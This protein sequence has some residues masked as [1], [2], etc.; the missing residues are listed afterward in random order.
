MTRVSVSIYL[1]LQLFFGSLRVL[2]VE[3]QQQCMN[4]QWVRIVSFQKVDLVFK[5]FN[6]FRLLLR[7]SG[8]FYLF[9]I[10]HTYLDFEHISC[11]F[12]P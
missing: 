1:S 2:E 7:R 10:G 5:A 4:A 12:E 8:N 11:S 3:I 6:S 9:H